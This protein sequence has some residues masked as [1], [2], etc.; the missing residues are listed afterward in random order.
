EAFS[1]LTKSLAEG[2]TSA[3]II[4]CLGEFTGC[5]VP[6]SRSESAMGLVYPAQNGI[7][8]V[9]VFTFSF[10]GGLIDNLAED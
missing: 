1:Y 4:S 8:K 10:L 6:L 5:R 9:R 3:E 7:S 2:L